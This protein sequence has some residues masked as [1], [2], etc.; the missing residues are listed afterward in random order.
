[1]FMNPPLVM[2]ILWSTLGTQDG[3]P[4]LIEVKMSKT[5]CRI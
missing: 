3:V 4:Y 2:E 5:A 1:M